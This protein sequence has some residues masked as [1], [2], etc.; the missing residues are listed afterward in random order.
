MASLLSGEGCAL[1][2]SHVLE[3]SVCVC[4]HLPVSAQLQ[5]E[6]R[7]HLEREASAGVRLPRLTL[8]ALVDV[9]VRGCV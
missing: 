8:T 2:T 5:V 3:S 9:L 4:V 6:G 7:S 1:L